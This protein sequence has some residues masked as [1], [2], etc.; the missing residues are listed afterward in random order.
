MDALA[1]GALVVLAVVGVVWTA[2]LVPVLLEL[3][4]ASWRL[5][6]FVRTLELELR[7]SLQ[8][9]RELI[10]SV[11]KAAQGVAEGSARVTGT[12]EA[13]KEA[14]DNLRVTTGALRTI[15]GSRLIPVASVLAGVRAG[16]KLLWKHYGRRR[17]SS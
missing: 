11:N 5:Q 16:F 10:R 17:E 6:E 12:L 7:P 8:E 4:R 3:R 14:G 9:L 15:F 13:L 2:L 1:A